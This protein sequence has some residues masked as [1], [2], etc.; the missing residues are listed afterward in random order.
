MA[1]TS[2]RHFLMVFLLSI[3]LPT[4]T[5]AEPTQQDATTTQMSPAQKERMALANE[6]N[7]FRQLLSDT[8]FECLGFILENFEQQIP[9]LLIDENTEPQVFN[10]FLS[11]Q[12]P[13]LSKEDALKIK[14]IITTALTQQQIPLELAQKFY[15]VIAKV[16]ALNSAQAVSEDPEQSLGDIGQLQSQQSQEISEEQKKQVAIEILQGFG[17]FKKMLFLNPETDGIKIKVILDDVNKHSPQQIPLELVLPELKKA[18]AHLS[19]LGITKEKLAEYAKEETLG[20]LREIAQELEALDLSPEVLKDDAINKP[21]YLQGCAN[22]VSRK[23]GQK[24]SVEQLKELRETNLQKLEANGLTLEEL[25]VVYQ[26]EKDSNSKKYWKNFG[27]AAAASVLSGTGDIFTQTPA[28]ERKAEHSKLNWLLGTIGFYPKNQTGWKWSKEGLAGRA[29]QAA[30]LYPTGILYKQNS[31]DQFTDGNTEQSQMALMLFDQIKSQY[32]KLSKVAKVAPFVIPVAFQKQKETTQH[33]FEE[34]FGPK[35]GVGCSLFFEKAVPLAA[36]A[37]FLSIKHPEVV[38][39]LKA[40]VQKDKYNVWNKA[41]FTAAP[42]FKKIISAPLDE[43]LQSLAP[44]DSVF[45]RTF[46]GG[47]WGEQIVEIA[48]K[49]LLRHQMWSQFNKPEHCYLEPDWGNKEK[50]SMRTITRISQDGKV[51]REQIFCTDDEKYEQVKETPGVTTTVTDQDSHEA[52][53]PSIGDHE[54]ISETEV[55]L[56]IP[57]DKKYWSDPKNHLKTSNGAGQYSSGTQAAMSYVKESTAQLVAQQVTQTALTSTFFAANRHIARAGTKMSQAIAWA[58]HKVGLMSTPTYNKL[59]KQAVG[60][61]KALHT[62]SSVW[63][64]MKKFGNVDEL[65]QNPAKM[66]QLIEQVMKNPG[67]LNPQTMSLQLKVHSFFASKL[68][69]HLV[70]HFI[71]YL[72][73]DMVKSKFGFELQTKKSGLYAEK[74]Q[75]AL[76]LAGWTTLWLA[77][78]A[79]ISDKQDTTNKLPVKK[80]ETYKKSESF[81]DS[82]EEEIVGTS[83]PVVASNIPAVA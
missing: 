79:M 38:A 29:L 21:R 37:A 43:K 52:Y 3:A 80:P 14:E 72:A 19:M 33:A 1:V 65:V 40:F 20:V 61:Q 31:L 16:Q 70:Q 9:L 51:T 54:D 81:E 64:A 4:I 32:P 82:F 28:H 27:L 22:K 36:W 15:S 7:T 35:L 18:L 24:I 78:T 55:P 34:L 74:Y 12:N 5:L 42:F 59:G 66:T 26:Q 23:I 11:T 2:L 45:W 46:L 6:I 50:R 73:N 77:A 44:K 57:K 71:K 13:P 69:L 63:Y 75:T 25:T 17:P 58:C 62:V 68:Y 47:Q 48:Y 10:A 8:Q 60:A 30:A 76:A 56:F 83:K 53:L 39:S 67:K 49:G 41:A